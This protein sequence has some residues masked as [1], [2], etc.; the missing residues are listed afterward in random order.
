MIGDVD[1]LWVKA[2]SRDVWEGTAIEVGI[3]AEVFLGRRADVVV[4]IR[5]DGRLL[6]SRPGEIVTEAT[7]AVNPGNFRRV[8]LSATHGCYI[9]ASALNLLTSCSTISTMFLTWKLWGELRCHFAIV[10]LARCTDA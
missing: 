7:R 8:R 2:V 3:S 5:L 9:R 4:Q 10:G 1:L 6:V